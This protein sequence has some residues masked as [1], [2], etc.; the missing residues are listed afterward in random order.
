LGR[1]FRPLLVHAVEFVS[2]VVDLLLQASFV[3]LI[4]QD[5]SLLLLVLVDHYGV[6]LEELFRGWE[7][8]V[9]VPAVGF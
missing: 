2:Q 9:V 1:K 6:G 7:F 5:Q 8:V 3:L 4:A